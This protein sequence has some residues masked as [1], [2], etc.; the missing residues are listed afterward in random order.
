MSSWDYISNIISDLTGV[1]GDAFDLAP[2]HIAIQMNDELTNDV[3]SLSTNDTPRKREKYLIRLNNEYKKEIKELKSNIASHVCGNTSTDICTASVIE[4]LKTDSETHAKENKKLIKE[5]KILTE[6]NKKYLEI[7]KQ[8]EDHVSQ[9]RA[10][11]ETLC[12]QLFNT[13]NNNKKLAETIDTLQEELSRTTVELLETRI[14]KN[15][16]LEDKERALEDNSWLGIKIQTITDELKLAIGDCLRAQTAFDNIQNML[17][18]AETELSY[19]KEDLD[20]AD[21]NI[22]F[23]TEE[24]STAKKTQSQLEHKLSLEIS[25]N[26]KLTNENQQ[27]AREIDNKWFI[28]RSM[29]EEADHLNDQINNISVKYAELDSHHTKTADE[30]IAIKDLYSAVLKENKQLVNNLQ[31]MRTE[32]NQLLDNLNDVMMKNLVLEKNVISKNEPKPRNP[33]ANFS[34]FNEFRTFIIGQYP[35]HVFSENTVTIQFSAYEGITKGI[36]VLL[37]ENNSYDEF[38]L[39]LQYAGETIYF[40]STA[41]ASDRIVKL[42]PATMIAELEEA[43]ELLNNYKPN[44]KKTTLLSAL[45]EFVNI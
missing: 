10:E 45:S 31:G 24:L 40:P 27:L 13:Q 21:E 42:S 17:N 6:S 32:R 2:G 33:N 14:I 5:C 1:E 43:R 9:L 36:K 26:I 28:I 35:I 29:Q 41:Y 4:K 15:D 39:Q 3:D 37:V 25:Q 38:K 8:L 44:E 20:T 34:N 16:L 18:N 30:L 12:E 23:Y 19:A 7:N 11:N 22:I